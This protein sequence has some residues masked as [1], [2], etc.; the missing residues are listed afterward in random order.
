[1]LS[2]DIRRLHLPPRRGKAKVAQGKGAQRLPPWV[3][4]PTNNSLLFPRSAAPA[5]GRARRTVE[6]GEYLL[7][8]YP[9]RRF[10]CPGLLSYRPAGTSVWLAPLASRRMAELSH[11][12]QWTNVRQPRE[13]PQSN[14]CGR[15]PRRAAVGSSDPARQSTVHHSKISCPSLSSNAVT[16]GMVNAL[17]SITT[18]RTDGHG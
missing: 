8:R 16:I 9:G 6:R 11:R 14:S 13:Q 2:A 4:G 5:C 1:M 17:G 15:S 12:R 7:P 18:D 10:A 3:T